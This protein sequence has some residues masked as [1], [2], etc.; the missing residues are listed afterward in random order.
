[1][2]K[3][4]TRSR[5]WRMREGCAWFKP[6]RKCPL[7]CGLFWSLGVTVGFTYLFGVGNTWVHRLMVV[8]LA[9]VIALTLFTIG[10]IEH[11]FS[12]GAR[13]LSDLS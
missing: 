1:M 11:P 8:S 12:G 13:L 7:S 10:V 2:H 4:W 5:G 6:R 9:A 3:G